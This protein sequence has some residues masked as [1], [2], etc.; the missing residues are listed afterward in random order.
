MSSMIRCRIVKPVV[1]DNPVDVD[2]LQN[3]IQ[4]KKFIMLNDIVE[5]RVSMV[6]IPYL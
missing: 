4:E 3:I 2:L 6:S 1:T 5:L